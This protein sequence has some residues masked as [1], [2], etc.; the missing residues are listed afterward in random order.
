M[1]SGSIAAVDPD[2]TVGQV[3]GPESS[4]AFSLPSQSETNLAFLR[5]ELLLQRRFGER[6]GQPSAAHGRA[7]QI[8][9]GFIRIE[10]DAGVSGGA[11]D[12]SPVRVRPGHGGLD[13]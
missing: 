8:D 10:G 1:G 5:L 2:I 6:G 9:I 13:E 3:T 7:L 4:R 12:A 11:E